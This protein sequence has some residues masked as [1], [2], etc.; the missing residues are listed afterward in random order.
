MWGVEARERKV[1]IEGE[2][3]GEIERGLDRGERVRYQKT[4]V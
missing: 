2:R 4:S 1:E 3:Y